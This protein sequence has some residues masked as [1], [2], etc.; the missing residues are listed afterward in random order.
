MPETNVRSPNRFLFVALMFSACSVLA[1]APAT[2]QTLNT[3]TTLAAETGNNTSTADTFVSQSNGNLG[4]TNISKVPLSSLLYDANS[5]RIYV[6]FMPWFGGANHMNVGYASNDS[7]QVHRQVNDM[8]SRGARGAIVDWYGPTHTVEDQTT[9][10][11]RDDAQTRGGSFEFAVM[12]DKGALSCVD[13]ASCTSALLSDISYINTTYFSSPA[14]MRVNGRPVL[15]FFGVEALP[16]DWNA[17]RQGALG[18][19]L[20]IFE[21]SMTQA[22]DDG[23]FSWVHGIDSFY[24]IALQYPG[25]VVYGSAAKGFNDTLASW[26]SNRITAQ[27]CGQWW[28]STWAYGGQYWSTS[29]QLPAL[30]VVTWNDYEEGTEVE[31]GIDNC[32]SVAAA[33]TGSSF[34][35]S[36]TG[37]ENTIDHY[38]VF[39]SLD[40][41]NLAKLADVPA[42]VHAF[43]VTT[44]NLQ[45]GAYTLFV[46]A[47]GRPSLT[48]KMAWGVPYTV[49]TSTATGGGTTSGGTT[50]GGTSSGGT[51][52]GGTTSGSGGSTSGSTGPAPDMSVSIAPGTV[53]VPQGQA[54]SVQVSVTP[55]AGFQGSVSFSCSNL[56][57]NATCSFAPS[58][59]SVTS[60]AVSTTVSL[61]TGSANVKVG[62][63]RGNDGAPLL[64]WWGFGTPAFGLAG[65]VF[66]GSSKKR[67]TALFATVACVLLTLALGACGS[68]GANN[69]TTATAQSA[70]ATPKGDYQITV[71]ATSGSISHSAI[72]TLA[73]Q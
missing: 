68:T 7:T 57:A 58:S 45:P 55:Q 36:V 67:R 29:N 35:W 69:S 70:T 48:N 47:I 38:T 8:M 39:A 42:G 4:A 26:G 24:Q 51:T 21:N 72:V 49:A 61:G 43:D 22:A 66:A 27:N 15:F 23:G 34:W 56:P 2:A 12:E 28:L 18:N 46:E 62:A 41:Q 5:T 32:V 11:L 63:V 71:T 59:V 1:A 10:Y 20:F 17:V 14:Y 3:T 44:A 64:H 40:G 73:V 50:S 33:M 19:P 31:S 16:M 30:Q 52:S 6:H 54:A 13:S 53:A 25:K 9:Q 65:L 60:S 37:S